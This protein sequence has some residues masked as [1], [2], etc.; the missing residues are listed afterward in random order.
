L[1]ITDRIFAT[2][3]EREREVACVPVAACAACGSAR[4]VP[5]LRVAGEIGE[6]GLIPTT[7]RYGTALGDIVRCTRCTHMQLDRFPAAAELADAYERAASH[8]YVDEEAGQRETARRILDRI[9]SVADRGAMLDLGCWVGF[10]LAEARER[11]WRTLGV[12]PS[13]FAARYASEKL[14]LDVVHAELQRA[15]LPAATF[16]AA[17]LGDVIEHLPDAGDALDRVAAA[18][19]PGGV[20]ALA[21][22][23]AGSRLARAMGGRWWAVVP[24]HVHYFTRRSLGT[25]LARTGFEPISFATAPKA[26]TVRYYLRRLGGYSTALAGAL[27]AA[28]E[29]AGLAERMWAP[30]FG[31]RMLVLARAP[32]RPEG[33]G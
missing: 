27:V 15:E 28:A 9:E 21:L 23:D 30:D 26:F 17:F 7:D 33:P 31:D 12:E 19:E 18:L 20:V 10:L 3:A 16:Q 29:A 24:T 1:S 32:T 11:G 2:G 22:P 25:L 6:P 4:L 13:E 14:G 5:H 8:D